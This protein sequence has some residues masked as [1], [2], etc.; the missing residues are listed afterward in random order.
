MCYF[1][2]TLKTRL[3]NY[4]KFLY[5]KIIYSKL[6]C[7]VKFDELKS[8]AILS[9]MYCIYVYFLYFTYKEHVK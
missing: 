1:N 2:Q 3:R 4:Y 8:L 7:I 9:C 6:C 5:K